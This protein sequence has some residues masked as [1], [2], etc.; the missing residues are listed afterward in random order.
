MSNHH[1]ESIRRLYFHVASSA[2]P[3]HTFAEYIVFQHETIKNIILTLKRKLPRQ[4][5]YKCLGFSFLVHQKGSRTQPTPRLVMGQSFL[6]SIFLSLFTLISVSQTWRSH[7]LGSRFDSLS[8]QLS[9]SQFLDLT[10][11]GG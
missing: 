8:Y 10:T 5:Q 6:L 7:I 1:L 9:P 3:C 4:T 2:V 11:L